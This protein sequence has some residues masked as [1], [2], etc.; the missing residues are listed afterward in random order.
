MWLYLEYIFLCLFV[1][2]PPSVRFRFISDTFSLIVTDSLCMPLS[3]DR[4]NHAVKFSHAVPR[5]FHV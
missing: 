4:F 2:V 5:L 1:L 3:L